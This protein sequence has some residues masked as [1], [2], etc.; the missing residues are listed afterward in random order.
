MQ[1][2]SRSKKV[3]QWLGLFLGP[4]LAVACLIWLPTQ[5]T[6]AQ[7]VDASIQTLS[8]S[9]PSEAST[10]DTSS[11]DTATD[12][13]QIRET[14]DAAATSEFS[15]AG[16]ATLAVM[17]WMGIWWL[18][19]AIEI[20]ATALLPLVLFPLLGATDI[21]AASA[22]YANY[23]I[24]LYFGGFILALSMEK[25]GLGKRIALLTLSL[26]GT[27]AP[28][29]IAGFML[30]TAVLSAFVSN[31]ATTAMML[32]IALS[33][34]ALVQGSSSDQK[35][36]QG[37]SNQ[38]GI[39]LLLGIAYAASVGGIMTIIGT[40]TNAFLI[41]FL[42]RN[43]AEPYRYRFDFSSWLPIGLSLTAV[44]LPIIY[45]LLTKVLFP[46]RGIELQGGKQLIRSELKRLGNV[47]RGEWITF[48]VFVGAVFG[49]LFRPL[50]TGIEIPWQGATYTPLSGIS[51]TGIAMTAALSLF[52]I[53]VSMEDRE[54]A[55]D[56]KTVNKMP[57]GI[58]IMFGGGLSLATAIANN[59]VAEFL[60]SYAG[61]IGDLPIFLT[62]LLVT[63]AIVFMTE[64]TSNVATTTS[65]VPVL[66]AVAP[67]IGIHPYLLI[68]PA[69]VVASCAFML[70]V[71]T[72]PNAIVFG[73]GEIELPQMI[74]AGIVLNILALFIVTILTFVVIKPWMGI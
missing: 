8:T 47:H 4:V 56:W 7:P 74:R 11:P 20:S 66:A 60:G 46:I 1:S 28:R 22:P 41:G 5:Y 40:P 64:L 23:L 42:E 44:F 63:A 15:W 19:E 30:V 58:L 45:L 51:D 43:I 39:C 16:R 34:I 50:L 21:R 57:W 3:I 2:S 14:Q 35:A 12:A 54:F 68:I 49:W 18:T 37:P 48:F 13:D 6:P 65:L 31:T 36:G 61:R 62:V 70:P 27:S 17:V 32:P 71:A 53:P 25:W 72:P 26:V 38:F 29:M 69:T 52:L 24:F 55:M 59:G 67:G 73:S 33:T 10:S 9:S